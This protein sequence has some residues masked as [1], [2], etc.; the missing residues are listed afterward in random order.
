MTRKVFYSFHFKRDAWR[1]AQVRNSNAIAREDE[2]GV[3]DS[4]EWQE[5]ERQG[6]EAI[7]R[8]INDQLMNTSVTVVL[9]G[10]ETAERDWVD[11]EI[12]QS[13]K[14]GNALLGVRI[15]G[16]KNH[17]TETDVPG[18][19]P[20]AKI[21]LG[22][23]T[24]LSAIIKVYDWVK[25]NGRANLG[26]WVENAFQARKAYAGESDL[27]KEAADSV[28]ARAKP[29]VAPSIITNPAKPWAR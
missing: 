8:W 28:Y 17:D 4:V 20:F 22:N 14:R 7:K 3:I 13:W 16:V 1:A 15:H 2:F 23:G 21:R 12:R 5:I 11:Y 18:A 29:V 19:S 26:T 27:A 24:P 10:A 6:D 9:I 25:D